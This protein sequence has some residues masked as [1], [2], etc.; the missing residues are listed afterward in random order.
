MKASN[1]RSR[2]EVHA[3]PPHA[4]RNVVTESDPIRSG[5]DRGRGGGRV[6]FGRGAFHR[7]RGADENMEKDRRT[8]NFG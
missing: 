2:L 6:G 1:I 4:F 3:M 5:R 7:F 8:R